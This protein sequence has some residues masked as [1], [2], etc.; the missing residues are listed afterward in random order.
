M[1]VLG[2]HRSGTSSVAGTL[3]HLGASA[4]ATL[5]PDHPDNPKGYWESLPL[6]HAS[7]RILHSAGSSWSDWRPFNPNWRTSVTGQ[8]MASDLPGLIAAEFGGRPLITFKDPRL[9]RLFP[10][11]QEALKSSGYQPL[12]LSPLRSPIEV[13]SSLTKRDGFSETRGL[14]LWLRHVLDAEAATR[15]IPRHFFYWSHF[16]NDWRAELSL[17][18][19]RLCANLPGWSDFTAETVDQF[20]DVKLRRSGHDREIPSH[21]PEWIKLA[22]DAFKALHED[23]NSLSAQTTLDNIRAEFDRTVKIYG[24]ALAGLEGERLSWS[25]ELQTEVETLKSQLAL[26]RHEHDSQMIAR[27]DTEALLHNYIAKANELEQERDVCRFESGVVTQRLTSLAAELEETISAQRQAETRA[28]E[29]TYKILQRDE[30]DKQVA[31]EIENLRRQACDQAT[32]HASDLDSAHITINSLKSERQALS[33]SMSDLMQT[34]TALQSSCADYMKT[35]ENLR[36]GLEASKAREL[37]LLADIHI[38]DTREAELHQ[39]LSHERASNAQAIESLERELR[40]MHEAQ[41]ARLARNPLRRW[42]KSPLP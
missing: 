37:Q 26:A 7:D 36:S 28:E 22:W 17:A 40:G 18:A 5:M 12:V 14:L 15:K 33:D 4:P 25:L 35:E 21:A 29:L 1:L 41:A 11:W 6:V 42:L 20:L 24:P 3:A 38:R 23:P 30:A 2:M 16:L 8:A 34:I 9:C 13:A 27:A 32:N 31:L 39:T 19:D 10:I